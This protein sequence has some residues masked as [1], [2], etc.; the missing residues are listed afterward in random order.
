VTKRLIIAYACE[1]KGSEPG[2][3]YHWTKT[4]SELSKDDEIIVITRKNNNIKDLEKEYNIKKI[5]IDLPSLLISIKKYLG[6]RAYYLLWTFLVFFHLL[7]NFSRYK[8][9]IVHHITFTP[10]YYPPLYF[11]LPFRYIWG[12]IGGGEVFPSS[13]LK[14]MKLK[15][16]LKEII[17]TIQKNTIFIN[18]VFYIGCKNSIKIICSTQE[19]A[20]LIPNK[21]QD[22]VIVELM[23]FDN[24]KI[25]IEVEREKTIVIANR[26]IHWKMTHL[27]VEAFSEY[28]KLYPTEYKLIIIGDGP[29]VDKVFPFVDNINI[30]HHKR[31]EE[32]GEMFRIL[33]KSSLFVSM[34]LRDSGAASLLEAIS[35]YIPFIATNSGAHRV[36]LDK[37][38]GFGFDLEDYYADK[39]KIVNLL[40]KILQEPGVLE[41]EAKKIEAVYK[42]IFSEKTKHD[43]LKRLFNND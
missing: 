38:I 11:I 17:R 31:F 10:I 6:V 20:D 7:K 33:R 30:F 13:Y 36:F 1:E 37:N 41:E 42:E 24:D 28:I 14:S 8:C 26:L 43:R 29:Y 40:K 12:P 15:D 22:K 34:S 16:A 2:V 23:V 25:D 21:Y 27:F 18:P 39:I 4:I 3:G 32:R 35:Y 5:G 19:T 9:L